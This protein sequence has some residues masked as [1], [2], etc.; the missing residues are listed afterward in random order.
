MDSRGHLQRHQVNYSLRGLNIF[1][2]FVSFHFLN[3][4]QS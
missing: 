2:G 1:F 3:Y 4:V